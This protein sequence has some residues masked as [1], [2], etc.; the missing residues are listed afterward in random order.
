MKDLSSGNKT[1]FIKQMMDNLGGNNSEQQQQKLPAGEEGAME[2]KNFRKISSMA[3]ASS[4]L[5]R[6]KSQVASDDPNAPLRDLRKGAHVG[7]KMSAA[8]STLNSNVGWTTQSSSDSNSHLVGGQKIPQSTRVEGSAG[9]NNTASLGETSGVSLAQPVGKQL[10][11]QNSGADSEKSKKK[12]RKKSHDAQN[13]SSS[14][15]G[16]GGTMSEPAVSHME[17]SAEASYLTEMRDVLSSKLNNLLEQRHVYA[18]NL[19]VM[20]LALPTKPNGQKEPKKSR[21]IIQRSKSISELSGLQQPIRLPLRRKTH[22]DCVLE[23]MRLIATD[24]IGERKWKVAAAKTTVVAVRTRCIQGKPVKKVSTPVKTE[25]VG[26]ADA[27]DTT[28]LTTPNSKVPITQPE[29]V[30]ETISPLKTPS[31][32]D[33]TPPMYLDATGEDIDNARNISRLL[34]VMVSDHWDDIVN[35]GV[36]VDRSNDDGFYNERFNIMQNKIAS[37]RA[38]EG[39]DGENT[40][41]ENETTADGM[42]L[43]ESNLPTKQ[44]SFDEISGQVQSAIDLVHSLKNQKGK[45]KP[46]S[47]KQTGVKLNREQLRAVNFVESLWKANSFSPDSTSIS[48]VL[49]GNFGS[50][51]TVAACSL[52]WRNR[53]AGRQ[54]VLCSP[55]AVVRVRICQI[56]FASSIIL[57]LCLHLD[58]DSMERRAQ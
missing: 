20:T 23:E 38:G 54:I 48:A 24:F 41:I 7:K 6:P 5:K 25:V 55:V 30:V 39:T 33:H 35:N 2:M 47:P 9:V 32:V 21:I 57:L 8:V 14:K 46:P 19:G 53:K 56:F 45:Q 28:M 58:E 1:T 37:N 49:A 16:V 51:K 42:D 31:H 40:E 27:E 12:K 3:G 36:L 18:A 13:A 50:G 43:D 26:T 11:S 34:S 22:W 29:S 15:I 44:L 17:I 4:I 10:H 52:I